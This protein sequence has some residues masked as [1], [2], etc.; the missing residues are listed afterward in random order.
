MRSM[1]SILAGLVLFSTACSKAP[2]Q[3]SADRE[4]RRVSFVRVVNALPNG[5]PM[6]IFAGNE[7][8]FTE[9]KPG[10][11]VPYHDVSRGLTTFRARMIGSDSDAPIANNME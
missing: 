10:A 2:R 1:L 5:S 11:V 8:V 4:D 6:D 9:V 7:K 3:Q